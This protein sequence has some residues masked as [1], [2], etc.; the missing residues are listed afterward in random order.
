MART[1]VAGQWNG[2]GLLQSM[3]FHKRL[4]NSD[5][6]RLQS[7]KLR[8]SPKPKLSTT[9]DFIGC[10][11]AVFHF[12]RTCP[13]QISAQTALS[14]PDAGML[15]PISNW[16]V[17]HDL[18]D[19]PLVDANDTNTNNTAFSS[20][21]ITSFPFGLLPFLGFQ[22]YLLKYTRRLW[23][24]LHP[25]TTPSLLQASRNRPNIR[26]LQWVIPSKLP[27]M[28]GPVHN[29]IHPPL[30]S[31]CDSREYRIRWCLRRPPEIRLLHAGPGLGVPISH[32]KAA[33][34]LDRQEHHVDEI[35][36]ER[37]QVGSS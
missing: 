25:L 19:P 6:P 10:F 20:C 1:R 4:E 12:S 16:T 17:G 5:R 24:I 34:C 7:S 27:L 29:A 35:I 13:Q 36:D 31:P 3:G 18:P 28:D 14:V 8:C 9:S 30:R 26:P 15:T 23:L 33:V 37:G 2:A 22:G 21:P 32:A 11:L